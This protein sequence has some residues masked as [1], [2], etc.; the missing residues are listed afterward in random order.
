MNSSTERYLKGKI[1]PGTDSKIS[2]VEKE[3]AVRV[4]HLKKGGQVTVSKEQLRA[5]MSD[6][7][8]AEQKADMLK[9]MR[10]TS[11]GVSVTIGGTEKGERKTYKTAA[12]AK[13]AVSRYYGK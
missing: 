8:S 10:K 1:Y 3:G 4:I 11:K 13:A 7:M 6:I 5:V 12:A 9:T 2:S